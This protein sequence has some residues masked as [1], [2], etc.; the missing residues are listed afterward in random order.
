ML[1]ASDIK[2]GHLEVTKQRVAV[3]RTAELKW[4]LEEKKIPHYYTTGLI[5]SSRMKKNLMKEYC[6]DDVSNWIE[7]AP[8]K[9]PNDITKSWSCLM[10]SMKLNFT[11]HNLR[12]TYISNLFRDMS[13]LGISLAEIS[14]A[15]GHKDLRTSQQYLRDFRPLEDGV[16]KPKKAA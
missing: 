13:L 4:G 5:S 16:Y 6:L 14:L 3:S 12:N 11:L 2:N 9:N 8:N 7:T 10:D 15:A 1:R